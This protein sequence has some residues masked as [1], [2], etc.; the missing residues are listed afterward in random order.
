MTRLRPWRVERSRR[1][2]DD[3]W[4]RLRA[5]DCVTADGQA[6]SP[7]YVLE[8]PDWV[9]VVAVSPDDR[10]LLIEQ[11]RHGI[12]QVSLELPAGAI[13]AEDADPIAAA[14]RE[15]AEETGCEGGAAQL[16]PA[17]AVNPASHTNRAQT[18]VIRDVVR[19]QAP[20][21]DPG[22]DIEAFWACPEEALAHA[23]AGRIPGLQA[24]SLAAAFLALGWLKYSGPEV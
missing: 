6:V 8:Y 22:E 20:A 4:L 18:V 1:L 11:Y 15:L 2:V 24:A 3:R 9:H 23:S 19:T 16:L 21:F 12:G 13:D 7:F 5:D 10:I 14:R 17:S